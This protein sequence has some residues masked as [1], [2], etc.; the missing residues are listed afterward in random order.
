MKT[1]SRCRETL[2]LEAFYARGPGRLQSSCK[3]CMKAAVRV[4]NRIRK[5]KL[6]VHRQQMREY[7]KAAVAG[8][9]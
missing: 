8:L 5:A 7:A 2:P 3:E 1:C 9:L 4:T 6:T